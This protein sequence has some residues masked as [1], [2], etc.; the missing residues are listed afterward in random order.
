MDKFCYTVKLK[1]EV[2]AFNDA[3]AFDIIQDTFGI[4]DELGVRVVE[5]EYHE[6]PKKKKK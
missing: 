1:V 4:G 3:D 2:N 5:C 6:E